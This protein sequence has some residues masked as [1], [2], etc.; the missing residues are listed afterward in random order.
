MRFASSPPGHESTERATALFFDP[1]MERY[2][3]PERSESFDVSIDPRSRATYL[4]QGGAMK[5]DARSQNRRNGNHRPAYPAVPC[6]ALLTLLAV[7]ASGQNLDTGYT[8]DSL[9]EVIVTAQKYQQRLQDVPLSISVVTGEQLQRLGATS[10]A[11]YTQFTPGVSFSEVPAGARNGVNIT[12]DGVANSRIYN[13]DRDTTAALTT[14]MYIDDV[15]IAPVDPSIYDVDRVE[16]LKGPQG[17]LFGQAT[18]G[19]AVR[20]ITNQPDTRALHAAGDATVSTY[21]GGAQSEAAD[22]MVNIPLVSDKLAARV[23]VSSRNDGGWIDF[24][25]Y[26]L[27][28]GLAAIAGPTVIPDFNTSRTRA[29]RFALRYTPTGSL[30]VSPMVFWQDYRANGENAFNKELGTSDYVRAGFFPETRQE[31]FYVGALTVHYDLPLINLTSVTGYSERHYAGAQ[32]TTAFMALVEGK[33]PDGSIPATNALVIENTS[34]MLTQELRAESNR[35]I[36]HWLQFTIGETYNQEKMSSNTVWDAHAWNAG[37]TGTNVLP[38]GYFSLSYDHTKY[39]ALSEYADATVYLGDRLSIGAGVR[40]SNQKGIYL[41]QSLGST[42]PAVFSP[43]VPVRNEQSNWTPRYHVEYELTQNHMVYASVAKGFRLGGVGA[44]ASTATQQCA[45]VLNSIGLPNFDGQYNSDAVTNYTLGTKNSWLHNRVQANVD[46]FYIKW[47]D[48]QSQ[49]NLNEFNSACNLSITANLGSATSKGVD[50]EFRSI[51]GPVQL[52]ATIGYTDAKR[53]APPQ[54]VIAYTIGEPFGGVPKLTGSLSGQFSWPI[55]KGAAV[56]FVRT[57][58]TARSSMFS[59][60]FTN[61]NDP[62]EF[63]HSYTLLNLKL[64]AEW[65]SFGVTLFMNNALNRLA[66][67]GGGLAFGEATVDRVLMMPPRTTGIRIDARF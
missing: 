43:H 13:A 10:L 48:L 20:F 54:G 19:G 24:R 57:D 46:A 12:I 26:S 36:A 25:T 6:G 64:G 22:G 60:D 29:A 33:N 17:T 8:S 3:L 59:P 30:T 66:E 45:A 27:G 50:A 56:G 37:A 58:V 2:N 61:P 15:Y 7:T 40:H 16:I 23:S 42:L 63:L 9:G 38:S 53:G 52:S 39:T 21:Q 32:D 1:K 18:M 55:L 4:R 41:G 14:A 51:F 65:Q 31:G 62:T 49:L 28:T 5:S 47:D 11:D 34:H 44:D 35:T 67:M